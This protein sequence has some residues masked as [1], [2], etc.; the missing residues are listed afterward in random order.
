MNIFLL[1]H[2]A[3]QTQVIFQHYVVSNQDRYFAEARRFR[4]ERWLRA[5][6]GDGEAAESSPSSPSLSACPVHPF[7]SLPF[8]YGRRMCI[9]RRF[10]ELELHTALAKVGRPDLLTS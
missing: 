2:F 9:G 8:G 4:P 7:A 6:A 3:P 1:V 5:P 10:A